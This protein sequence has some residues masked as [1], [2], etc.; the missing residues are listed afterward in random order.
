MLFIRKRKCSEASV[1]H[2]Y[3][4][5]IQME[6]SM[7]CI[8]KHNILNLG[9]ELELGFIFIWE[10]GKNVFLQFCALEKSFLPQG[11]IVEVDLHVTLA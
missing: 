8:Q 11:K 1:C 4:Y 7:E 9:L 2:Y 10:S 6:N 5:N 3:L